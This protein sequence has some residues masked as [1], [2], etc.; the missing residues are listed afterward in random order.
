MIL[1]L[2]NH[3]KLNEQCSICKQKKSE[4]FFH[5]FDFPEPYNFNEQCS[6]SKQKKFTAYL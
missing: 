3:N 5:D 1:I 4:K 6:L 2:M